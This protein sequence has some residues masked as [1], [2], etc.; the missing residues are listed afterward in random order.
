MPIRVEKFVVIR[1]PICNER[2]ENGDGGGYMV[3]DNR[4]EA[5]ES[6]D[7]SDL[8]PLEQQIVEQCGKV[9]QDAYFKARNTQ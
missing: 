1:C 9:C 2:I 5:K 8:F 3:F 6:F 7:Y 4:D